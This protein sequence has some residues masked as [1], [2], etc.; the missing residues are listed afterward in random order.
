[1]MQISVTDQAKD[2]LQNLLSENSSQFVRIVF[3]GGGWHG[4]K[5]GI[6]LDE[7]DEDDEQVSVDGITIIFNRNFQTFLSDCEV[8]YYDDGIKKEFLVSRN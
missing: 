5:F 7:L 2:E 6:A 8:D 4:V 1:M 3:H